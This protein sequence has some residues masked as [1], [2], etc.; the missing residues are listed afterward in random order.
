MPIFMEI[1]RREVRRSTSFDEAGCGKQSSGAVA[2]N[3]GNVHG[4]S[5]GG[6]KPLKMLPPAVVRVE[7]MEWRRC[8]RGLE[9]TIEER[10]GA[11]GAKKRYLHHEIN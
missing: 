3:T 10:G 8:S 5:K 1:G 11:S 4:G 2:T 7:A 6:S 9:Q